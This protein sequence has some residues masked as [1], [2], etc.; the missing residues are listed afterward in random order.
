M[1][2]ITLNELV[3]SGDGYIAPGVVQWTNREGGVF[4]GF[5]TL[6]A[7]AANSDKKIRP[8]WDLHMPI[9]A[10]EDSSCACTGT[11]LRMADAT[12]NVR[13]DIGLTT[14]ERTAFADELQDLVASSQFRDS[15]INLAVS[16]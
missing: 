9:V 12:I 13:L 14:A 8:K 5:Q 7:S 6:R 4:A 1:P 2:N 11:V 3:F 15:L 16:P 10:T